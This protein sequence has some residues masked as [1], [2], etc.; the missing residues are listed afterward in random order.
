MYLVL[1]LDEMAAH[2]PVL[3]V[4]FLHTLCASVSSAAR[5]CSSDA[6]SAMTCA[7]DRRG[8]GG[9]PCR[10]WYCAPVARGNMLTPARA[11]A[12]GVATATEA[13]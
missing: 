2:A 10:G 3:L 9:D 5:C 1:K 12:A 7:M 6:R 4:V 11:G 8:T 13:P